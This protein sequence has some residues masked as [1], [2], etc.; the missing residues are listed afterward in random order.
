MLNALSILNANIAS[1]IFLLILTSL[2]SKKFFATCWVIVDA[3]SSLFEVKIFLKLF[4]IALKTPFA[5]TPGCLKKFLS[6]ADKKAFITFFGIVLI[7]T[8]ILF[9]LEKSATKSPF[10]E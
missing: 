8:K 4:I 1:L 10:P 9:S 5:S 2:V 6:S 7:G 3:P